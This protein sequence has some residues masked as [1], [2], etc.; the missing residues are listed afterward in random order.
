[1]KTVGILVVSYGSR[2]AAIVDALTKSTKYKVELYIADK[3]RNPF[4]IERAKEHVVVPS[5]DVKLICDFTKK[6]KDKLD[7]GIV[8]PEKPI[9][10]GVRDLIEKE[11]GIPVICPTKRYAIEASKVAQRQLLNEIAPEANPKF[12]VFDPK[13]YGERKGDLIND[14]QKWIDELGG[15]EKTVIKPDKPGFGK[16]V[17]VGG[18]HYSNFD[19]AREIFFGSYGGETQEKVIIEEKLD[20][21]ESSFQAFCD[22]KHLI[23]LP[24]TRD[25][26]RAFDGDKGANTGGMGSY[27]D[28]GDWLPFMTVKDKEKEIETVNKLFNHMKEDGANLGLRGIP[29]YVAFIHTATGPKILE[30]NS[31]PGDPEIQNILPIIKDDFVDICYDMI[32]GT[33]KQVQCEKKATVTIYKVPPIYGGYAKTYPQ[34]LITDEMGKPL[35][36]EQ[37]K[38]LAE[39]YGNNIRIY[40]GSMEIREDGQTY[41]LTSRTVNVVGIA[42]KIQTARA[43]SLEGINAIKGGALWNRTDIAS[44]EHIDRSREHM[45]RL[46]G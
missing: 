28:K 19:Q 10:D 3:Q 29:F 30:I 16:G 27:K 39:K 17:G 12:Q 9:I 22:G 14:V 44:K 7:F 26:K 5:L 40:P 35:N 42:E 8:G 18:E 13:T 24:E 6:H 23:P 1:M 4:N 33:L 31:R 37:A 2:E 11:T 25:N 45:Q 38:K 20:G 46:R 41:A 36:L 32:N 43:I 21:E 15:V 34:R